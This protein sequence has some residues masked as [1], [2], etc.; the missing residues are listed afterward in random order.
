MD[1]F[2]RKRSWDVMVLMEIW[3]DKKEKKIVNNLP[4][5]YIWEKQWAKKKQKKK[6]DGK[7]V[8]R[9]KE[10][11]KVER[12]EVDGKG[13]DIS[14]EGKSWRGMVENSRYM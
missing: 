4:K 13:K 10:G 5:R 6:S 9:Y 11:D 1:G 7:N 12:R 14:E 3:I 2:K 8:N